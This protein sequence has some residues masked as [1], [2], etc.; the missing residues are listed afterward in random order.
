MRPIV[1]RE[2]AMLAIRDAWRVCWLVAGLNCFAAFALGWSV[3]IDVA[4]FI[5]LG[6]WLKGSLSRIPAF[7]LLLLSAV[8]LVVTVLSK[9]QIM[10]GGRNVFLAAVVAVASWRAW[11]GAAR[12]AS[13]TRQEQT[14]LA[15]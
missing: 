5:G 15:S 6:I 4:L 8:E 10:S 1:T 9:L 2:E 14:G 7:M 3:L 11:D 13:L 12:I